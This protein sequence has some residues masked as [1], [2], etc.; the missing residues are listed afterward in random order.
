MSL[1]GRPALN[2]PQQ[3]GKRGAIDAVDDR[4][5]PRDLYGPLAQEFRFTLDA[6]ASHVNALCDHF[7]DLAN[8]GLA[9]TWEGHRVW[10]NPPYSACAAW[11]AKAVAESSGCPV[12]V[13]LLPANRT[14][15]SWWQEHIEPGRRNGSIE[16][17]FLAGRLRFDT[18][19]GTYSDPRGNRPPFGVCLVIFR[20]AAGADTEREAEPQPRYADLGDGGAA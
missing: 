13:M 19:A 8:D 20:A 16:V 1:V 11:V 4:R 6:A 14:E 15:Q 3:T 12:I 5:T 9:G 10:C 7:Y 18:P 17:R 2:H